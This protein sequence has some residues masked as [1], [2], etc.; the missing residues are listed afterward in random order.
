MPAD[1]ELNYFCV[2]GAPTT[3]GVPRDW[4]GHPGLLSCSAMLPAGRRCTRAKFAVAI[5]RVAFPN[6]GCAARQS[7]N[8]AL[9]R[10]SAVARTCMR[11]QSAAGENLGRRARKYS[12]RS[13][14][15]DAGR[16]NLSLCRRYAM[17]QFATRATASDVRVGV[18]DHEIARWPQEF[19]ENGQSSYAT[20][21]F[22]RSE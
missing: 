7:A 21:V 15:F 3:N 8:E 4:L 1:A 13:V 22:I 6:V 16:R 20:A 9:G 2:E 18:S 5:H 12:V 17:Q 11:R 19:I 14:H 10:N